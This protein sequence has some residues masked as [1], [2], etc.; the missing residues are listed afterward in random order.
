MKTISR[1]ELLKRGAASLTAGLALPG[2]LQAGCSGSSGGKGDATTAEDVAST[3]DAVSE[4]ATGDEGDAAGDGTAADA[5]Q[6][7]AIVHAVLAE[8]LTELPDMGRKAA[9]ALGFVDGALA[10]KTVFIKPNFVAIGM[11]V[12]GC[13]FD[14]NTGECTKPELVLGVA[15]QCLEAGAKKVV[16]GEGSQ[17]MTWDWAT[18]KF[19]TGNDFEGTTDLQAAAEWL[20]KQ[21]GDDRVELICLNG[22]DDWKKVPSASPHENVKDGISV[23]RAVLEADHVISMPVIKTHQWALMSGSM[24]NWFGAASINIH[25]NG[26]SRCKL[27]VAYDGVACHG[28]DDAGVSGAFIDIVKWRKVNGFRDYAIV[29]GS[30]CLEGSGPH[31]APV[32]DGKTILMKDRNRAK[33]FFVLASDDMVA[34]DATIAGIIGAPVDTVKALRMAKHLDLGATEGIGI[35]GA[36]LDDLKVADWIQPVI[37][38]ESYFAFCG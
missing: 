22:A 17:T 13:G 38:P 9:V 3:T 33:R 28:L 21:Y 36:T 6:Y 26:I 11:E 1:R 25:G 20:K 23:A 18:V 8:S 24:K 7:A 27:H 37:Q 32:N 29:D 16:I 12:F 34:A 35:E 5:V 31:K 10:G 14:A 15:R 4:A 2:L 30:I 19:V